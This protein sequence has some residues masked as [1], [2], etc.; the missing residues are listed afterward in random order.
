MT[1]KMS[2]SHSMLQW[3]VTLSERILTQADLLTLLVERGCLNLLPPQKNNPYIDSAILRRLRDKLLDKE[4][5]N[6][7]LEVSTKAGL[8]NTSE[9]ILNLYFKKLINYNLIIFEGVF[10]AW[11]KSCLKAGCLFSA[12]E[13]FQRCFEKILHKTSEY[14]LSSDSDSSRDGLKPIRHLRISSTS[15]MK[16]VRTPPLLKEIIQMLESNSTPID[17][18]LLK[19]T[20]NNKLHITLNRSQNLSGTQVDVAVCILN[21]LKH[22]NAI[23]AGNYYS[24]NEE[25]LTQSQKKKPYIEPIIYKECLFYLQK[26]GT[27]LSLLE[28]Y[29]KH[30]EFHDALLY[31]IENRLTPD[32]FIE[33]YMICLKSGVVNKLQENMSSIDSTLNLWKVSF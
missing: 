30:K 17:E 29:V 5:W 8:D 7:A 26:Y 32:I 13:K 31:L 23:A 24:I 16:P 14:F 9:F 1:A 6:L 2:C 15:D 11:G 19:V 27:H 22:L 33:I 12:R 20:K 3:G 25:K 10:A 21:K 4:E 28:F 18:E